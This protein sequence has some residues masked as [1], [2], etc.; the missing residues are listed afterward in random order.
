M[1][2]GRRTQ[3]DING[4]IQHEREELLRSS[5]Q[6]CVTQTNNEGRTARQLSKNERRVKW[7]KRGGKNRK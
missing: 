1:E 7:K 6:L 5:R 3:K 2:T 4:A